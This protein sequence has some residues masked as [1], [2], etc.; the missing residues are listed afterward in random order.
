MFTIR[1]P[2]SFLR[3]MG[4]RNRLTRVLHVTRIV[5]PLI[6]SGLCSFSSKFYSHRTWDVQGV[7]AISTGN[8][9]SCPFLSQAQMNLTG[10][11]LELPVQPST[12]CH[13]SGYEVLVDLIQPIP[14]KSWGAFGPFSKSWDHIGFPVT[15]VALGR[16]A[17]FPG[18]AL[19]GSASKE[20]ALLLN[21]PLINLW[22]QISQYTSSALQEGFQKTISCS[23]TSGFSA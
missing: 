15:L 22:L 16:T 19:G 7:K 4:D 13:I 1:L 20:D 21:W 10:T 3:H 11:S 12:M 23:K 5:H 17:P 2:I 14:S 9:S 6:H 8:L 18:A